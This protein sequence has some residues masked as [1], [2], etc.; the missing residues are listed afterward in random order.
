MAVPDG[1]KEILPLVDDSEIDLNSLFDVESEVIDIAAK[2]ESF[3]KALHIPPAKLSTIKA[4]PGSTPES[5][6]SSTLS[7]FL[8]KNYEWEEYGDPSWRLIVAAI[9]HKA[10][11]NNEALALR[12]AKDH[13]TT[14]ASGPVSSAG[15]GATVSSSSS[16]SSTRSRSILDQKPTM[17]LIGL[18]K[19]WSGSKVKKYRPID[20][21]SVEWEAI[22]R[23][24][25]VSKAKIANA[26]KKHNDS[27]AA[28]EV[29]SYWLG[30]GTEATWARLIDAIKVKEE[31]TSD[32]EDLETALLNMVNDD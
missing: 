2:W 22:A 14:S 24:L 12:I 3:G 11:G 23:E 7:E 19:Y 25:E 30:S 9:A 10:G 31:L 16:S 15:N 28:S 32:A 1:V 5:C 17:K 18:I 4:E 8:K 26:K 6:L 27:D 13:L 21:I 20:I 29:L